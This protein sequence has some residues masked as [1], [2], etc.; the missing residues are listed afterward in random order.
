MS[1]QLVQEVDEGVYRR[2]RSRCR[3]MNLDLDRAVTDALDMWLGHLYY[4]DAFI[5][6]QRKIL[7]EEE[8][9]NLDEI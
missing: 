9:V 8:F 1:A 3:D 7:C 5:E 6:R 2:F 4:D